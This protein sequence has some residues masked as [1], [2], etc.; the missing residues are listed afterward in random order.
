MESTEMNWLFVIAR[1][2]LLIA[3]KNLI[4]VPT[5]F[6]KN[7]LFDRFDYD[8]FDVVATNPPGFSFFFPENNN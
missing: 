4:S 1:L 6:I 7:S 5:Y 8:D 3:F 2:N